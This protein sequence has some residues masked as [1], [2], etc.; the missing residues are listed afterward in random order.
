MYACLEDYSDPVTQELVIK[1]EFQD[2]YCFT[3][4]HILKVISESSGEAYMC[5]GHLAIRRLC[6]GWA[7]YACST[8]F[9]PVL[10]G[11]VGYLMEYSA[12]ILT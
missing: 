8:V 5:S 12:A 6:I 2:R 9:I 7:C 1:V 4:D 11:T 3:F 10:G